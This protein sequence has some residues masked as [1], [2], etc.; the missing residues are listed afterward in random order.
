MTNQPK[1]KWRTGSQAIED[2]LR[3][4]EP[5]AEWLKRHPPGAALP[6]ELE[7]GYAAEDTLC[8]PCSSAAGEEIWH[9]TEYCPRWSEEE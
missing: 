2:A 6:S 1:R 3:E 7:P 4:A 9:G 8:G 5:A